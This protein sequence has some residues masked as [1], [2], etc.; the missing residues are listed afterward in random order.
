MILIYFSL[1]PGDIGGIFFDEAWN[2]CGPND[3]HAEIYRMISDNTKRKHPG[4]YTVLNPGANMSQCF[5]NR[6]V[7]IYS[8]YKAYEREEK[9]NANAVPTRS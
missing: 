4:A 9:A 2:E 3:I 6:S 8:S 7:F 1:F 5:E